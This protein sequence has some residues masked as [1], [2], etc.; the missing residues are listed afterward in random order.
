MSHLFLE[1]CASEGKKNL[2]LGGKNISHNM[3][4]LE[5]NALLMD[6]SYDLNMLICMKKL[7]S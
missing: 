5:K 6:D 7:R 3:T 1:N 2:F 4:Y